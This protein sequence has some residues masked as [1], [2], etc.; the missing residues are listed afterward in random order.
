MHESLTR[1]IGRAPKG[2]RVG[3]FFDTGGKREGL[4]SHIAKIRQS[5]LH[6]LGFD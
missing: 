6:A 2:S 5:C 1:E 4:R 3:S